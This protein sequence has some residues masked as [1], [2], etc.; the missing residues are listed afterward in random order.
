MLAKGHNDVELTSEEMHRITLWLDT[1]CMF[2]GAYRDIDKQLEGI[3]V[4]PLLQ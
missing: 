1:N 4:M 3:T 2:Y